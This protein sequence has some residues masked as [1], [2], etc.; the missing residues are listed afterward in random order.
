MGLLRLFG[1]G[2]CVAFCIALRKSWPTI[3]LSN[4][5]MTGHC[6]ALFEIEFCSNEFLNQKQNLLYYWFD[7]MAIFFPWL[8]ERGSANHDFTHQRSKN[9]SPMIF[10]FNQ[11]PKLWMNFNSIDLKKIFLPNFWILFSG[12]I[13]SWTCLELLQMLMLKSDLLQHFQ[14]GQIFPSVG[15]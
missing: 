7:R 5:I 2:H 14:S 4:R 10:H 11:I 6:S 3:L 1:L 15:G 13:F 9:G 12:N 8:L